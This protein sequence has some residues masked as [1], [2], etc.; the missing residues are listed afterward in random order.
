MTGPA[1]QRQAPT[2]SIGEV[3][4][5][6]QEH[7]PDITVSKIRFLESR[8]LIEPSRAASGYRRF[9]SEDVER[10]RWILTMQRDHFL[11]LRVI[12]E[13]LDQRL[14]DE[15][16]EPGSV[17]ASIDQSPLSPETQSQ[18]SGDPNGDPRYSRFRPPAPAVDD[19]GASDFA[20]LVGLSSRDVD[21]LV[22][23]GLIE[24]IARDGTTRFSRE[25]LRIG[26]AAASFLAY[27]IEA[28]HLKAWRVAAEREASILQQVLAPVLR[29]E[30]TGSRS[31]ARLIADNLIEMGNTIRETIIVS[32]LRE[33]LGVEGS[34]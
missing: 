34:D 13:R 7:F 5:A 33:S 22:S 11:P 29:Q 32:A 24:P 20:R 31:E 10:L 27:G 25:S 15:I 23:F 2:L 9:A 19:V 12:K 1:Q 4:T 17:L 26:K 8:G 30:A 28:R 14:L 3:L 18:I 6:L 16:E 21:S